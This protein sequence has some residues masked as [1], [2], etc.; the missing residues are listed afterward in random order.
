M[1]LPSRRVRV[2]RL[3]SPAC[4][5]QQAIAAVA[6][7]WPQ[8]RVRCRWPVTIDCILGSASREGLCRGAAGMASQDHRV[9]S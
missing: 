3:F 7:G 4:E 9:L 2:S 6:D 8:G 5:A 1:T